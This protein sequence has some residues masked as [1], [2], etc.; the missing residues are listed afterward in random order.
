MIEIRKLVKAFGNRAVLKGVDLTVAEG[1]FLTLVGPN[2]AGKTTLMSV[3]STLSKPT[4][5]QV[6]VSG[7]N[8]ADGAVEVRRQIGLVSHKTLLYDD[9]SA[10]Q[11]L[12]FYAR[13]YDVPNVNTRIETV[14]RRVGLWGRQRD[15]VR[16]YSRGMQQRLAIA[17]AMLH[18]PPILLLDEP[19]TGL[20]QHA[21]AMLSNLLHEVGATH[22][23]VLMTTHN[24]E[25]GL[26]LGDRV[27]ILAGGRIAYQADKSELDARQFREVYYQSVEG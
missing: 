24:L 10:E 4:A 16:T 1:E 2:G 9:L 15:P 14:L 19:D 13:M 25:R 11:N 26:E 5:G 7:Y 12:H 20:D 3:I 18:D 27:A 22:R 17:R 6:R 21:A 8:L 23:T